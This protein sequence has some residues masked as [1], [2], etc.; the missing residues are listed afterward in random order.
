MVATKLQKIL[1]A[2]MGIAVVCIFAF[3]F[4]MM[5]RMMSADFDEMDSV[6]DTFQTYFMAIFAFVGIIIV[7]GVIS[8]IVGARSKK[9]IEPTVRND[10]LDSE[11]VRTEYCR[12]CGA[13]LGRDV[14]ECPECGFRMK[15]DFYHR[16]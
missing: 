3:A 11:Y 12:N 1:G 5:Y 16:R 13:V 14:T 4:Y 6:F 10:P 9:A 7:L 8:G 2:A 15:D